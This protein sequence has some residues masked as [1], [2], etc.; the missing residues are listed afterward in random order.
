MLSSIHQCFLNACLVLYWN[1]CKCII[2]FPTKILYD[3][4]NKWKP[5]DNQRKT[6]KIAIY[7]G[8]LQHTKHKVYN[9]SHLFP[10]KLIFCFAFFNLFSSLDS[11]QWCVCTN[12]Y[13]YLTCYY[14]TFYFYMH[15]NA[16]N[17]PSWNANNTTAM[18][19]FTSIFLFVKY[20]F[21]H[22]KKGT[23]KGTI[24]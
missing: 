19:L 17:F 10:L 4:A 2:M 14:W 8:S 1:W 22:E 11:R 24:V 21:I 16:K 13:A 20:H 3:C 7:K 12:V 5:Q 23:R 6:Y 18:F 15:K 9:S